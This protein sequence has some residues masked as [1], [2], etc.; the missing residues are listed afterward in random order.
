VNAFSENLGEE[1]LAAVEFFLQKGRR[2]GIF[3]ESRQQSL[4]FP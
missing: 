1:G 2:E 4:T 3:P